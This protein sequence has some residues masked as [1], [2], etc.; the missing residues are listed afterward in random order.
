ML[1]CFL[2][3]LYNVDLYN[4]IILQD[5]F[6]YELTECDV[7]GGRWR[8][9]VPNPGKCVSGSPDPPVRLSGCG[10]GVLN[11]VCLVSGF[12]CSNTQHLVHTIIFLVDFLFCVNHLH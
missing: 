8:V 11:F 2:V 4:V 10:N 9:S 12:G 5:D 1:L 3:V 6:H 7:N